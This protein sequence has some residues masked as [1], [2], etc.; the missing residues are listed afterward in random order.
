MK[1]RGSVSATR[2]LGEGHSPKGVRGCDVVASHMGQR[3]V[4]A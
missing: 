4:A 2:I 3:G 1:V